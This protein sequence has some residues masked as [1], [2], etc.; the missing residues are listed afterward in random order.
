M[1][2]ANYLSMHVVISDY[3]L[4]IRIIRLLQQQQRQQSKYSAAVALLC[5][6]KRHF[7]IFYFNN[8]HYNLKY[9]IST[10]IMEGRKTIGN[11]QYI[12]YNIQL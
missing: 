2:K 10:G 4:L 3:N 11:V 6:I 1:R 9:R 12:F 8:P 5:I 7:T